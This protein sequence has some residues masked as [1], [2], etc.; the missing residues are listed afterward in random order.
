LPGGLAVATNLTAAGFAAAS[1][2][3]LATSAAV[4]R[5]AIPEMLKYRY[6][7]ALATGVVAASGTLGAL[8]PPSIAFVIFGFF[9]EQSVGKLLIAGVIPGLLTA[10]AYTLMIILRAAANPEIAP[11]IR[12]DVTW[13]DRFQTLLQI[14]PLP[15]LVLG[16][17]GS[18]YAGV[19]TPTEAGALGALFSIIIGYMRGTAS[20]R[21]LADAVIEALRTTSSL[22]FLAIGA[23]LL[24]RFLALSGVPI[25][26][27]DFVA[28]FQLGPVELV[29]AL[30]VIYLIM[31]MFL[32]PLG[33]M[34]LTLPVFMPAFKTMGVDLI[35]I[36]VI[37]VKM[38][39][40]GLL[41]PPVGLNVYVVKN[42]VGDA[43]GLSTIFR[44]VMWFLACEV[45][46]MAIL[47]AWPQVSLWLP[48][49][50]LGY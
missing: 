5:L 20:F 24:T 45:V 38:I 33:V 14:W 13:K 42:V 26:I 29:I 19:A 31:G 44:G 22:F 4:G 35:W 23:V 11:R 47:I 8:I 50:M 37:V 32:D 10:V 49:V 9:T 27:A 16:V 28:H 36:G 30:A 48:G 34:L 12:Q 6:D 39:E 41:T 46:I 17:V 3:S 18:I 43:V 2:S 25:Y 40:I 1:G 15:L 7:P 21:L